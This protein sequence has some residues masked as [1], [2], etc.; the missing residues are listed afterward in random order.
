MN[1]RKAF[2]QVLKE[3]RLREASNVYKTWKEARTEALKQAHKYN[4]P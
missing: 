3:Q 4:L 1:P 2:E